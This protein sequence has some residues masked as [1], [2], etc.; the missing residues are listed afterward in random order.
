MTDCRIQNLVKAKI[1]ER[2]AASRYLKRLVEIGVLE[3]KAVGREKLYLHPKLLTLLT[4]DT[5]TVENY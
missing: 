1:C 3:E 4:R 5:N 2:Q